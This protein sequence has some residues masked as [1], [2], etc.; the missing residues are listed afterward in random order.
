MEGFNGVFVL[1]G[2]I[3]FPSRSPPIHER[4]CRMEGISAA[5][6]PRLGPSLEPV[7]EPVPNCGG[8]KI[9]HF[10]LLRELQVV[11]L[12]IIS[13]KQEFYSVDQVALESF[14]IRC[15]VF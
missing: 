14:F 6:T 8:K 1:V 10:V 2:D 7:L 13:G 12:Y 4:Y 5:S 9:N 11:E 3:G 15:K